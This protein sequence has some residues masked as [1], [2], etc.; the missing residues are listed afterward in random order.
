MQGHCTPGSTVE[1][2]DVQSL[3]QDTLLLKSLGP[4]HSQVTHLSLL[5][6][7]KQ[8]GFVPCEK[9]TLSLH[10]HYTCNYSCNQSR[11]IAYN[12]CVW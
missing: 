1:N 3:L 8:A 12:F 6:A 4:T 7:F 10:D 9:D 2:T 11:V 5:A